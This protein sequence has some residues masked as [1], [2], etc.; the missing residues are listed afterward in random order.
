MLY[1]SLDSRP[2]NTILYQ[3][4]DFRRILLKEH[5]AEW[6]SDGDPWRGLYVSRRVFP[7]YRIRDVDQSAIVRPG[8]GLISTMAF[9]KAADAVA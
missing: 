6:A 3:P 5:G 7:S 4:L 8:D 2:A 1:S 9:N